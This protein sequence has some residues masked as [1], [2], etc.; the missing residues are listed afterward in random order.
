[1]YTLEGREKAKGVDLMDIIGETDSMPLPSEMPDGSPPA[2]VRPDIDKETGKPLPLE[3]PSVPSGFYGFYVDTRG[4]HYRLD[5]WGNRIKKS[6]GLGRPW[7]IPKVEWESYNQ[8]QQQ[9]IH[10]EMDQYGM[11]RDEGEAI[12]KR[13]KEIE[14]LTKLFLEEERATKKSSG[15]SSSG[16]VPKLSLIHI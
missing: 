1:M 7:C 4:R 14:E 2:L 16:S 10:K 6:S 8:D 5:A 11:R 3:G 12:M 13:D 9:K 15:S